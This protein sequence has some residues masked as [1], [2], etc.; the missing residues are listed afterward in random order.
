MVN[1]LSAKLRKSANGWLILALLAA[2]VPFNAFI[3]PSQRMRLE[4]RSGGIG[5]IDPLLFYTPEEV[6][7]M[8]AAYGEAGR[9]DYRNSELTVDI[10]YPILYTLFFALS[11]SRLF[12]LGFGPNSSMH[13]LNLL[14]LGG[15]L[16]DLL[17]N[18]GIVWMLS[19]HPA[20]PAALAW[21]SAVFTLFKWMFAAAS[22]GLILIGAI[23]ALRTGP[24]RQV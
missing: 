20:T 24:S 19:V 10:I 14:P 7:S 8:I 6:Y 13:Q 2:Q 15:W 21:A 1:M 16:F 12:R 4:A 18:L 11:I 9:T 17:E 5:P 22:I 23:A 3:F